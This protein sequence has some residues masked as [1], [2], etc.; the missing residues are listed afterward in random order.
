MLL[1][2]DTA[3]PLRPLRDEL[4]WL[5]GELGA[6]RDAEVMRVADLSNME[7]RVNVNE[8]DV[9]N[10]KVGDKAPDFSLPADNGGKASL[11]ALKGKH[12][13]IDDLMEHSRYTDLRKTFPEGTKVTAKVLETG[14]GRMRLS[15]KAV[16][17][18]EERADFD[19][20]REGASE[21]RLGTFADLLR[22]K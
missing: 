5:A 15:L 14:D 18:D 3:T 19:G 17:E 11:K 13:I 20:F 22:K 2:F 4:K 1:A 21:K 7:V 8:N 9:V 16:K 12:P 6:A 10:V